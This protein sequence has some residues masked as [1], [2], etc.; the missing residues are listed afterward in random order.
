MRY[1]LFVICLLCGSFVHANAFAE[2]SALPNAK[3]E[4]LYAI[5]YNA[6][7]TWQHDKPLEEQKIREHAVYMK[8]LFDSGIIHVAGPFGPNGGIVLFYAASQTEAEAIMADDPAVKTGLFTGTVNRY[9][10]RFL[11]P[12][13][14]T[15]KR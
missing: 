5:V 8:K 1:Y 9:S 13:P 14:L 15:D 11:N 3:G 12:R 2:D 7:P 6:G 4:M 10:A